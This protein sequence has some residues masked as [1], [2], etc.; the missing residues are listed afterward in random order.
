MKKKKSYNIFLCKE[1]PDK[2]TRSV[3]SKPT[4]ENLDETLA[5]VSKGDG[6][7]VLAAAWFAVR[8][9]LLPSNTLHEGPCDCKILH[10]INL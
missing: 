3:V 4:A 5:R 8:L 6:R 10:F 2:A 7:E 1:L 9:S